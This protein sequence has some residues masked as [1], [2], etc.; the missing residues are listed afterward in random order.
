MKIAIRIL[1][2]LFCIPILVHGV[3]SMFNPLGYAVETFGVNPHGV[4]GMN[5]LRYLGGL[6]LGMVIMMIAGLWSRNTAWFLAVA[7]VV[8]TSAIGRLTS[9]ALDGVDQLDVLP[10]IMEFV[11]TGV[12]LLAHWKLKVEK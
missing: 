1:V 2:G 5:T 7:V 8:T 11:L 6:P 12:M 9:F 3:Q 4:H 10:V